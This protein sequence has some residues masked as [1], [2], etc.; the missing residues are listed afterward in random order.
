MFSF[1]AKQSKSISPGVKNVGVCEAS[2]VNV[3]ESDDNEAALEKRG[4]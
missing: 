4:L 2:N 1:G 3:E